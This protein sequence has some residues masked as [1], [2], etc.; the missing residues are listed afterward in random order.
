MLRLPFLLNVALGLACLGLLILLINV[1]TVI[2]TNI[3]Q[4][5]ALKRAL[6]EELARQGALEAEWARLQQRTHLLD[7][8]QA[9]FGE[10]LSELPQETHARELPAH[11]HLEAGRSRHSHTLDLFAAAASRQPQTDA[12]PPIKDDFIG[13]LIRDQAAGER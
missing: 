1:K 3:S 8:G 10:R 13:E 4:T 6:D 5:R 9:V 2:G 11:R 12:P 7:L